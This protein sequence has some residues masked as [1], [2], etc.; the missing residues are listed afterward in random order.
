MAACRAHDPRDA[1]RRGAG[2]IGVVIADAG[3]RSRV[4]GLPIAHRAVLALQAAGVDRVLVLGAENVGI[5]SDLANDA[6]RRVDVV[7]ADRW[8]AGS[9]LVVGSAL[10][11]DAN[12]LRGLSSAEPESA[13]RD[14][15]GRVVAAHTLREGASLE[16]LAIERVASVPGV[17]VAADD[18][19]GRARATRA[20]LASLRKPMDG[21]ISRSLNR[22]ISLFCTRILVRTGIRPNALSLAV[23]AIGI[24]AGV[25]ASRGSYATL[26][27]G[28]VL[29]QLQSIL[30]GCDGELSRL[31]FRGSRL[32]EWLDTIGDDITNYGYFAGA[33]LG[34]AAM[35]HSLLP[36][37]VGAA[38]VS[39][40]IVASGIEY[41][42]LI[43]IGS[44]DLLKYPLGFGSDPEPV[45]APTGLAR[46]LGALRPLLKRDTFVFAAMLA[47]LAGS[48]ATFGMLALFAGGAFA[49]LTAVLASEMR[50]KFRV[51]GG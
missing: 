40:G 32:G 15:R 18:A 39:C 49:T 41:R 48:V 10:V 31:T 28:G 35:W 23:L 43:A 6:R 26:A 22:P 7:A 9:T 5:A 37:W 46:M 29:F 2:V 21:W 27:I 36:M 1:L 45:V 25:L 30:D 42:Y 11:V 38:G 16:S 13:A 12:A 3:S 20:L 19:D 14:W 17:L 34:V 4:L 24:V 47:A 33:A 44:G 51:P 50:R 8:P